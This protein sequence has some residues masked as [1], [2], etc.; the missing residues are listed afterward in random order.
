[1]KF[2]DAAKLLWNPREILKRMELERVRKMPRYTP[3]QTSLFGR[4][5]EYLDSSSF[6]FL[7]EEIFVKEVYA[8][9]PGRSN[10][11][12][13][14]GGANI[15][16]SSLYFARKYPDALITAFEPD[17]TV[18]ATLKKN[19]KLQN[20]TNVEARPEA[21]WSCDAELA[22]DVEGADGGR[23]AV[24]SQ[25]SI[26]VKAVSMG[27]LLNEPVDFLKLDV[28]GS[29]FE[30]LK[31]CQGKLEM[32]EKAFIEYHSRSDMPQD[33]NDLL[34]ILH[35]SGFRYYITAPSVFSPEPFKEIKTYNGIDMVL[36]INCIRSDTIVS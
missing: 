15:G 31:S 28:E 25:K 16:L 7:H 22:F 14:D 2:R 23:I 1:M 34:T 12:I 33:L 27:N 9:Y 29:E 21:L 24:A 6:F 32:V 18:A 17:P 8:F 36:N 3:G 20:I 13:I 5:F 11:R 19:L 35:D 10:P 4:P 30:I 26:Q